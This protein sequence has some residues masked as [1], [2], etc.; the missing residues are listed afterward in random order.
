MVKPL[1]MRMLSLTCACMVLLTGLQVL[2]DSVS[3]ITDQNDR[4]IHEG[5]IE[6]LARLTVSNEEAA[7]PSS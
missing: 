4:P 7:L 2:T 6:P 1:V 5:S 3:A